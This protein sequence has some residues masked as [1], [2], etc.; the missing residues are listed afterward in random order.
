MTQKIVQE[1]ETMV[2]RHREKRKTLYDAIN[3]RH[4]AE[5][6]KRAE[7]MPKGLRAVWAFVTGKYQTLR[8]QNET[9]AARCL[10]RDRAEKETLIKAQLKER[11]TLQRQMR[12][13]RD[14]HWQQ[15]ALFKQEIGFYLTLAA[16]KE[17]AKR[18]VVIRKGRAER[19]VLPAPLRPSSP[20]N[21]PT[22]DHGRDVGGKVNAQKG[23][24][25]VLL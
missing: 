16:D 19:D 3:T 24:E 23:W 10:A 1:R 15:T 22:H 20:D 21:R 14:K 11:A 8:R 4:I 6:K 9:E 25:K 18:D 13:W 17:Q 12:V 2:V 5:T 7:R